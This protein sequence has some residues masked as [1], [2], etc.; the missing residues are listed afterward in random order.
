[1]IFQGISKENIVIKK[2]KEELLL[3]GFDDVFVGCRYGSFKCVLDWLDEE[4][5]E[6]FIEE[7]GCLENSEIMIYRIV[8]CIVNLFLACEGRLSSR[9]V[10]KYFDEIY[11][12]EL[13]DIAKKVVEWC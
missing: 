11:S 13:L 5:K 8:D 6:I 4:G 3:T 10:N 7:Y 1:M 12:G 9:N 2:D